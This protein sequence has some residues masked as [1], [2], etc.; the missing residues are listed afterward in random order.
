LIVALLKSPLSNDLNI[1][2][3]RRDAARVVRFLIEQRGIG[4]AFIR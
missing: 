1:A 2:V 3:P 4:A